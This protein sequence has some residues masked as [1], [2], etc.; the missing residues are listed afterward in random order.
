MKTPRWT[1]HLL[2]GALL[3]LVIGVGA[4]GPRAFGDLAYLR[5]KVLEGQAWRVLT[6]HVVHAG[7]GHLFANV[8][9]LGL[10]W[11]VF[12]RSA[13]ALLWVACALAS[14]L[15]AA[16]GVLALQPR[17]QIMAGLS[18][19]L[20]GLVGAGAVAA[21]RGGR[22]LGGMALGLLALKIVWDYVGVAFPAA[23]AVLGGPIAAPAHLYGAAA[24]A[25]CALWL[26]SSTVARRE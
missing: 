2:F 17:V 26:P 21:L 3:V 15:A 24:G 7:P 6:M 16:G 10:V 4:S 1:S 14:A 18:S 12:A 9:G 11:A 22:R 8:A 25:L 23:R 19:V 20:H 5:G 13:S